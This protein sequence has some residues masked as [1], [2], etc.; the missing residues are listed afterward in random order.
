ML[1]AN[2]WKRHEPRVYFPVFAGMENH[3][4]ITLQEPVPIT[5][6]KLGAPLYHWSKKRKDLRDTMR[7]YAILLAN[8]KYRFKGFFVDQQGK[9]RASGHFEGAY[10]AGDYFHVNVNAWLQAQGC[11]QEDGTFILVANHGRPDLFNSSPG[12][13]TL[14]V[15]GRETVAGYR[16]GFFCRALNDGKKHFGFTGLN[17]QI[18]VGDHAVASLL[19][20]NHSSDPAYDRPA[21]PTV[22]LHRSVDEFLEAPFGEIPPHASMERRITDLFPDAAGFLTATGGKGHSVTSLKGASLASV[23]V[24]RRPDGVL[25]SMEHSR[26]AYPNIVK[27]L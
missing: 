15:V 2:A 6:R 26:P 23:H 19:F 12:N 9:P 3:V 13:A 18:E 1:G 4:D 7:D 10:K 21:N 5:V 16:T 14:R 17:P 24:L 27:Y 11:A 22:R 20:V 8:P 25:L